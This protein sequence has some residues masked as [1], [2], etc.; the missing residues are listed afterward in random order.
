MGFISIDNL[1]KNNKIMQF[2]EIYALEKVDG[3]TS[4]IQW[5]NGCLSFHAGGAPRDKFIELFDEQRLTDI[6]KSMEYPN[7]LIVRIHGEAYGG[8]IQAM[9][10]TY[11]K[12]LHFIGFEVRIGDKWLDVVK[13]EGFDHAP[14]FRGIFG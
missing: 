4:W 10:K 8:K 3:T 9:S 14:E 2:K 13:A 11:G 5:S 1:Y 12:D 6:F 7:D